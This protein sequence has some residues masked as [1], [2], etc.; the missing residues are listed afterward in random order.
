MSASRDSETEIKLACDGFA[1]IR[2]KLIALGFRRSKARVFESNE[3]FDT[4]GSALRGQG[5]LLRLRRA[6]RHTILTFKGPAVPGKHKTREE[7][8]TGVA[9]EARFRAIL[10]RLG[11]QPG[12]RYEKYRT[13]YSDGTGVVTLDETPIGDYL[14]LEGTPEW[15]DLTAG[16]LGF[17]E[18]DYITKSY[19]KL[20]LEFCQ[21]RGI[22]P[23]HMVFSP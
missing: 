18:S 16:R 12:F 7:L 1:R 14:E 21:Q 8:E 17:S 19:G 2:R 4:A 20:Y 6:G 15:I 23:T 9:D 11:Y 13:E 5:C 10:D 3:L 22:V